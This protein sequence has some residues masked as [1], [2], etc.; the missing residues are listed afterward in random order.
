MTDPVCDDSKPRRPGTAGSADGSTE[1]A[2]PRRRA[3]RTPL[4]VLTVALVGGLA[5][6][7][8]AVGIPIVLMMVALSSYGS[9][10]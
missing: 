6:A 1:G 7:G 4:L 5:L 9:N 3:W 2:T 10:K 8:L